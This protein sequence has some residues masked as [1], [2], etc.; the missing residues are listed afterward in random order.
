MQR[1]VNFCV[2]EWTIKKNNSMQYD[3]NFKFD[4]GGQGWD[5]NTEKVKTYFELS[6]F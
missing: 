4:L 1:L 5:L 3:L 6:D 2:T